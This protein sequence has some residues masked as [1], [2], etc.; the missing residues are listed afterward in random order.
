[1]DFR[2]G[3][4]LFTFLE[5]EHLLGNSDI[6]GWAGSGKEFVDETFGPFA[7]KQIALSKKLHH[8]SEV[9]LIQHMDCGAYGGSQAFG[10]ILEEHAHQLGELEKA[11]KRI[12]TEYPDLV[13]VGYIASLDDKGNST[14]KRVLT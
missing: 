5:K 12:L 3:K 4:G 14:F 2:F 7:V 10:S 13:V 9:H 11:K 8:I 6:A 1:M